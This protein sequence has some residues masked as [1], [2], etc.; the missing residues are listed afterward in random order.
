MEQASS[1]AAA[2]VKGTA[3]ICK[4]IDAGFEAKKC[5]WN[6][7]IMPESDFLI[8]INISIHHIQYELLL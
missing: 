3:G 8:D 1:V 2:L 4:D 7:I 6:G 5:G